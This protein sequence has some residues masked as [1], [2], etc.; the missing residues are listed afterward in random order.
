MQVA[1]QPKKPIK[2]WCDVCDLHIVDS[3]NK[4]SGK[5]YTQ[6]GHAYNP[7]TREYDGDWVH[8]M[9]AVCSHCSK[10]K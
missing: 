8:V 4:K 10:E 7:E 3:E 6:S 1:I 2:F 5:F 9:Y